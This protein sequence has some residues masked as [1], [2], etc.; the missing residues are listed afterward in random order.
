MKKSFDLLLLDG[1]LD[2]YCI[3]VSSAKPT[4]MKAIASQQQSTHKVNALYGCVCSLC[5]ICMCNCAYTV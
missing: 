2:F 3:L 1:V 4:L 5:F